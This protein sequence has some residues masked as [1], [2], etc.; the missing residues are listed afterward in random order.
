MRANTV[1]KFI[2]IFRYGIMAGL[3]GVLCYWNGRWKF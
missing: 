2:E 1:C 3:L